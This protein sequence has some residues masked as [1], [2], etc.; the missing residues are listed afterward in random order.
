M[1]ELPDHITGKQRVSSKRFIEFT[2]ALDSVGETENLSDIFIQASSIS[3]TEFQ[4]AEN[5][6][7][8]STIKYTDSERILEE[9]LEE[10]SQDFQTVIRVLEDNG[11]I[12]RTRTYKLTPKA[13][14]ELPWL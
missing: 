4:A 9:L 12:P 3:D 6:A 14:Q 5:L 7:D 8:S 11:Y 10:N 13:Y 1:T 2:T